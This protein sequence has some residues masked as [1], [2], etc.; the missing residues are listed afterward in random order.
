MQKIWALQVTCMVLVSAQCTDGEYFSPN[1]LTCLPL[2]KLGDYCNAVQRCGSELM[3]DGECVSH[4]SVPD[5][6]FDMHYHI[7]PSF[8]FEAMRDAWGYSEDDPGSWAAF[9]AHMGRHAVNS[10]DGLTSPYD[11]LSESWELADLLNIHGA[12]VGVP[13]SLG[14]LPLEEARS[15]ARQINDFLHESTQDIDNCDFFAALPPLTDQAGVEAEIEYVTETL[16]NHKFQL[17]TQFHADGSQEEKAGYDHEAERAPITYAQFDWFWEKMNSLK[18]IITIHPVPP[19]VKADEMLEHDLGVMPH[20]SVDLNWDTG[21]YATAVI[22]SGVGGIDYQTYQIDPNPPSHFDRYPNV[23]QII[24]HAG[25]SMPICLTRSCAIASQTRMLLPEVFGQPGLDWH[26][27]ET[28][29]EF[30]NQ[31]QLCRAQAHNFWVDLSLSTGEAVA[32]LMRLFK[33]H[34]ERIFYG[35]DISYVNPVAYTDVFYEDFSDVIPIELKD[36]IAWDNAVNFLRAHDH[37]PKADW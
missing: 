1:R 15:I 7:I 11:L 12:V 22:L 25:G 8:V 4:V 34:P 35:S 29:D 23:S 13:L 14:A 20:P 27:Q 37:S 31:V 16:G 3:C 30:K 10:P 17:F 5:R 32:A 26:A 19:N 28:L 36:A 2:K 21:R 18:A 6:R 9:L 24:T 33:D